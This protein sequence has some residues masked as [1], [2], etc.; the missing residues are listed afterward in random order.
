MAYSPLPDA[1]DQTRQ[2]TVRRLVIVL[3]LIAVAIVALALLDR[4]SKKT[5]PVPEPVAKIAQPSPIA[6]PPAPSTVTPPSQTDAVTPPPATN[7]PVEPAP[8]EPPPPPAVLNNET[9]PASAKQ[10]DTR[11]K[12]EAVVAEDTRPAVT[13][14][15]SSMEKLGSATTPL[16]KQEST[17][18]ARS[19]V[20]QLGVF[21]APENAQAL[22]D[23]LAKAGIQSYTETRVQVG[24]FKDRAEADKAKA[25]LKGLGMKSV[26]V[27]QN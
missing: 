13:A 20:L 8:K 15:P 26:I 5:G 7:A 24:P 3:I 6:S 10:V 21:S 23:R 4:T 27:P 9:L 25:T 1:P 12:P 2:R 16:Q 18:A 22:Q 19:F 11:R 17:Q 14:E